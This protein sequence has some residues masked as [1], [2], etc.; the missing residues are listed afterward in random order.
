MSADPQTDIETLTREL[1]KTCGWASY[2]GHA[3]S[4]LAA[5]LGD[6]E[7]L[8]ADEQLE[9]S[10][11]R[12]SG[13]LWV[14]TASHLF[15]AELNGARTNP[16]DHS[17][18]TVTVTVVPWKVESL[19]VV[20][21]DSNWFQTYH[22]PAKARVTVHATGLD[23]VTLPMTDSRREMFAAYLPTLVASVGP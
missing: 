21:S 9:V 7:V 13:T 16:E 18:S 15:K 2:P 20:G 11:G 4:R 17:S 14:F 12:L 1:A 22:W 3:L 23:P 8:Y 5:L 6:R 19:E 10:D